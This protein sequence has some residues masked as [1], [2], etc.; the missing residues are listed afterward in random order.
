MEKSGIRCDIDID[1][2]TQLCLMLKNY[3]FTCMLPRIWIY[4]WAILPDFNAIFRTMA[5]TR[6]AWTPA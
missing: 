6:F 5:V 1:V 4:T 2:S 3:L